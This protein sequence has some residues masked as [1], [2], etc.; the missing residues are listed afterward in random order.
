[1]FFAASPSISRRT[2]AAW[3]PDSPPAVGLR[4]VQQRFGREPCL[5]GDRVGQLGQR[6][7]RRQL[8]AQL[9]DAGPGLLGEARTAAELDQQLGRT[10]LGVGAPGGDLLADALDSAR[11]RLGLRM[12]CACSA[13][14]V[15]CSRNAAS[16]RS[17]RAT[18]AV[19]FSSRSW[20]AEC[21]RRSCCVSARTRSG[22]LAG[23]A[24]GLVRGRG[25][26]ARD[27]R[28]FGG[29]LELLAGDQQ[30]AAQPGH[31]GAQ[32]VLLGA[33]GAGGLVRGARQARDLLDAIA[34]RLDLG[35]H[36]AGA[37]VD[38]REPLARRL[39]G[40][41]RGVGLGRARRGLLAGGG[42]LIAGGLEPDLQRV[43]GCAQR[44]GVAGEPLQLLAVPGARLELVES[45]AQRVELGALGRGRERLAQRIELLGAGK[46]FEP[47]ADLVELRARDAGI[48]QVASSS[49]S[50]STAHAARRPPSS[51]SAA[52]PASR[53]VSLAP[54]RARRAAPRAPRAARRSA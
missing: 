40:A 4:L 44:A 2:C 25:T 16:S 21:S 50:A 53:S 51:A 36:G 6:A 54:A 48:A 18:S 23:G 19:V 37:A 52:T 24:R 49:L 8:R 17:R 28:L 45:C 32:L 38:L 41:P 27:E 14:P 30:L 10:R 34:V 13:S 29:L 46:P 31:A 11:Q 43:D 39:R 12:R 35:E 15:A 22:I 20:P 47:G 3:T 26:L 33:A 7:H 9:G 1:M 42:G 5:L